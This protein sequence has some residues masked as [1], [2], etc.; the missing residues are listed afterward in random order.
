MV[1]NGSERFTALLEFNF[2]CFKIVIDFQSK[3]LFKKFELK[4]Q[5]T[6]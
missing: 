3:S 6:K 2:C 1:F 5:Y 4:N